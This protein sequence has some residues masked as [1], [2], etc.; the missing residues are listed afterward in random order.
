[1]RTYD[2]QPSSGK[3]FNDCET[4]MQVFLQLQFNCKI[5][6]CKLTLTD[7]SNPLDASQLKSA[8]NKLAVILNVSTINHSKMWVSFCKWKRNRCVFFWPLPK[9]F[10]PHLKQNHSFR[11]T[12]REDFFTSCELDRSA[13]IER[14]GPWK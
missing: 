4:P 12:K 9:S 10:I 8:S 14:W 11:S 7:A 13:E 5:S 6:I 2:Y 3:Y 1:M